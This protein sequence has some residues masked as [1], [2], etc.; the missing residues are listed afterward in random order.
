MTN[1]LPLRFTHLKRM[2]SCPSICRHGINV[3]YKDKK[4]YRVG[5]CT[6]QLALEPERPL[7]HYTGVRNGK[8][9]EAYKAA[10]GGGDDIYIGSEVAPAKRMADAVMSNKLARELIENSVREELIFWDI[11]GRR[12]RGTI[13][14]NGGGEYMLDLKTAVSA[15]PNRFMAMA[16]RFGY[17]AQLDWY[18]CG[19]VSNGSIPKLPDEL[20]NIVVE[21]TEPHPVTVVR[22]TDS[23]RKLGRKTWS[24]WFERFRVC[25]QS[26][27]WPDYVQTVVDWEAPDDDDWGLTFGDDD[28]D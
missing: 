2:S 27:M 17:H 20:F 28:D 12:C 4:D 11:A 24:A 21:K 23:V 8:V 13:D 22:L 7:F 15:E 3:G 18:A 1:V 19:A 9:W 10:H 25:E 16:L 14:G 5:R 26:N 6:H